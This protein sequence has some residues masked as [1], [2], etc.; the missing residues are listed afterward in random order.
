MWGPSIVGYGSYRYIYE[1]GRTGEAPLV[2]FA[3]RGRELVIYLLTGGKQQQSLLTRVG[4]HR[5]GKVCLYFKRLSDLDSSVLEKL[6]T[7]SVAEVRRRYGPGGR[8]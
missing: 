6:V 1:S 8:I 2:G 7:N 4:K 5:R 3:I